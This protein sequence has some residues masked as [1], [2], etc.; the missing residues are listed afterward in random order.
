M[1]DALPPVAARRDPPSVPAAEIVLPD[2]F[3]QTFAGW[4]PEAFEILDRL[5]EEPHIGQYKEERD[6]GL[7]DEYIKEPFKRY[8]DDIVVNWVLPNQLGFETEK[9]VFSRLLKNDFGAGGCHH[10]RWMAFYRPEAGKRLMDVQ[11]S[12]SLSD[13]GLTVGLYVGAYATDLLAQA[14][15]RIR[16]EPE[17]YRALVNALLGKEGRWYFSYH[18]GSGDSKT[19]PK[20]HEPLGALPDDWEKAD[21]LAVRKR[22]PREDVVRA[23]ETVVR[24]AMEVV[25]DLWP[26]YRFYLT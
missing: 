16:E 9:R 4:Q 25:M 18:Y 1:P 5:R 17:R 20:H 14:K 6:A 23:G 15:E 19:S 13:K 24:E 21:G 10:H 26:L 12:H 2:E 8:R 11:L 7:L 22:L 3:D